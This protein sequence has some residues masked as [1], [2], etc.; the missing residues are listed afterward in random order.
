MG[1]QVSRVENPF[2]ASSPGQPTMGASALAVGQREVAEV[3][4]A[5]T[6]AKAYPRNQQQAIERILDSC[7]RPGLAEVSVYQ[8]ARGGSSISGPSIRLA[9]E[10]ARS[11][12]NIASGIIE[13]TRGNGSSECLAYCWDM[14]TN[15]RDEKRFHVKHWRDTKGGGYALTDERDI[16]EL[17][18]NQGSRRKR[19]C[20]LSVIPGDVQESA[21]RQCELTLRANIEITAEL[22][23]K[24]LAGFEPLGITKSMIEKKIQ[25]RFDVESVGP[26]HI[27]TL[28]KIFASLKDGMSSPDEWF[29]TVEAEAKAAKDGGTVSAASKM[30]A[31]AGATAA[32]PVPVEPVQAPVSDHDKGPDETAELDE[33]PGF[34]GGES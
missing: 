30:D 18:A 10:L 32:E 11:W 2:P 15:Y 27:L 19:A 26:G 13:L 12:G 25:R 33:M 8:Y 23:T 20:I 22:I 9:E 17:I 1:N 34:F 5:L 7:S 4:A 6:V 29:E 16:Y 3:Q 24:T 21:V 14:E 31:M 28:R